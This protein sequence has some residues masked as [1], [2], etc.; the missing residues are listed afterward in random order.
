MQ[1]KNLLTGNV[2][3]VTFKA[4][5]KV[6]TADVFKNEMQFLYSS[7]NVATFMDMETFETL[8]VPMENATW[9][10]LLKEGITVKILTWGNRVIGVSPPANVELKVV[11]TQPGI[12][13]SRQ[14]AGTKPATL[15][16]GAVVNVP[17]FI[18]E[19]NVV[20]IDTEER[21]YLRRVN[22]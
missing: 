11:E 4:D 9:A 17:L 18:E 8:E 7:S 16:S 6:E 12:K 5:E 20:K 1:L 2:R 21:S 15:E 10:D 19:G 14:N 22:E 13:G 3:D